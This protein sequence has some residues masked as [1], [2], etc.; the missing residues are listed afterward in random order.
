MSPSL[1]PGFPYAWC[2]ASGEDEFGIWLEFD[3]KG[4][5]QRMR[6]ICQG[7]YLMGSPEYEPERYD[8][9]NQHEVTLTKGFWLA[10]TACSQEL[11][12]AVMETNPSRFKGARKPV[13]NVSWDDCMKFIQRLNSFFNGVS[14]SLPTE[15][16]WEYACRAGTTTPFSFGR[17]ITTE[18][19]NYNG[20]YPYTIGE[21]GLNRQQTVEIKSLPPNQWGLY[22]MHGNVWE[23]CSDWFGEYAT[24]SA[25]DPVGPAEG[26]YRVIKG[27]SSFSSGGNCRCACRSRSDPGNRYERN[28]FR[29]L[30]IPKEVSV[31]GEKQASEEQEWT[32]RETDKNHA[33]SVSKEE[34]TTQSSSMRKKSK[35]V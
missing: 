20:D 23:W 16:Q 33:P 9:E 3:V 25:V 28:G 4:I 1:P 14:F 27:G 17:N 2:S 5:S 10:D 35:D 11:W 34:I 8:Y 19:V 18:Q 12:Q 15:A 13:E 24:G 29:F 31:E 7:K 21:K 26:S 22:E 30:G 32:E 6:W